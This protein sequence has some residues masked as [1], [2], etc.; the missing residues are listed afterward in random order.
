V[1]A[2]VDELRQ[3]GNRVSVEALYDPDLT[4]NPG[5]LDVTQTP[6]RYSVG[7]GFFLPPRG[8]RNDLI[9]KY[10]AQHV[11]L[12]SVHTRF[13]PMT[14][15]GIDVARKLQVPVVLTEHGSGFV[16]GV[17]PMVAIAS[18]VIDVTRGRMALRNADLV[19]A[20]S[21]AAQTFVKKL[22]GVNSSLFYNAIV[23]P[24]KSATKSLGNDRGKSINL[25]FV[26]RLVPG[27]GWDDFIAASILIAEKM[28][29]LLFDFHVLGDGPS[30]RDAE[31]LAF[32]SGFGANF[33]FHGHVSHEAVAD[34]LS[35]AIYVNPSRLSEGFQTT[36]LEAL[37]AGAR[38]VTYALPGVATLGAEGAPVFC[39]TPSTVDSL[40]EQLQRALVSRGKTFSERDM[41]D[42]GWDFRASQFETLAS[43][44]I[45]KQKQA[46]GQK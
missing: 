5:S 32:R 38:I 35:G 1:K 45:G 13:F 19:L 25:V 9:A 10:S 29:S 46:E 40:V 28:P 41:K 34:I 30:R 31:E 7:S 8:L 42:W 24:K 26:G 39:A 17:S 2:L 16:R 6:R 18:R 21:E 22:A 12:I 44:V 20:I 14:W 15:T 36:L 37:A 11:D 3:R 4:D 27:K 33:H 23:L 43:K